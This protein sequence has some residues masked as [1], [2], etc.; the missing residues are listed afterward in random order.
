M[1]NKTENI[2]LQQLRINLSLIIL[3]KIEINHNSTYLLKNLLKHLLK[4]LLL[5]VD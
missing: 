4:Y 1:H 3:I 2:K 5:L